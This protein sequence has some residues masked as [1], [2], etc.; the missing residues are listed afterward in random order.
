MTEVLKFGPYQVVKSLGK[1]GMGEVFLVKD[2]LCD[3]EVALKR[4]RPNLIGFKTM[5]ERFIREAKAAAQLTH[6]SIL[7]VYSIHQEEDL[8]YYTMPYVEGETLKT[9]LKSTRSSERKSTAQHPIGSSIPALMR[10]FWN[11]CQAMA[12]SHAQG[13]LHRDLKPE[14]V[15]I[16]KY[17]ETFIL[18]WGLAKPISAP[19]EE[20]ADDL[21]KITPGL[22]SPG[23]IVGT[24]TYMAPERAKGAPSSSQTDIYSLGVLL[25]LM[26]TLK[27]PFIRESIHTF[28]KTMHLEKLE[29]PIDAAPYRDI[30]RPIQEIAKKCL[31]FNTKE[32][33]ATVA[34]LLIDLEKYIEG[35]PEWIPVSTLSLDRKEDWEFQENVAMAKYVAITRGAQLIE[36]VNMMVAKRGFSGNLRLDADIHLGPGCRGIGFL[37]CLPSPKIHSGKEEGYCLWIGSA[38]E[39]SV[40]LTKGDIELVRQ[41]NSPLKHAN[42]HRLRIERVDRYIRCYVDGLL[43]LN[44]LSH[45]PLYGNFMGLLARDADFSMREIIVS[46][47]SHN[48]T[49]NCLAVPDALLAHKNYEEALNEYRR[50]GDSF[51]GRVESREALFRAGVTLLEQGIHQKRKSAKERLLHLANEEFFKLRHTPGAPLEYLGKSLIYKATGDIEEEIKCLELGLRKYREHPLTPQL[52]DHVIFRMH[53]SAYKNRRAAYH[54]TLLA[55]QLLP[56]VFETLENAVLKHNL[57]DHLEKLSFVKFSEKKDPKIINMLQRS[58]LAF[59]LNKTDSLLEIAERP[60]LE[61]DGLI[62]DILFYLLELGKFNE[63]TLLLSSNQDSTGTSSIT[64]CIDALRLPLKKFL[65]LHSEHLE[66]LPQRAFHFICQHYLDQGNAKE[67]LPY[68][69]ERE[70]VEKDFA[71]QDSAMMLAIQSL[72]LLKKPKEAWKRLQKLPKETRSS[73]NHPAFYLKACALQALK[74]KKATLEHFSILSQ[75]RYPPLFSLLGHYVRGRL[76]WKKTW[77]KSAFAYEKTALA[78]QLRVWRCS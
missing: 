40:I 43:V 60:E 31:A 45:T 54:F 78:R 10:I 41:L 19:E 11:I 58:A 46:I 38:K 22:T 55:L 69:L 18:D 32:R 16:G 27:L 25:Y 8:I 75:G 2:P 59:W 30:P 64:F 76:T 66:D 14:N 24:L 12:Y 71:L 51:P 28:R 6:P 57:F 63:A 77:N 1:G 39:P 74:G 73:E 3:R 68:I 7:P 49:V 36:W 53:E 15:M 34:E 23:K 48:V 50:I 52:I 5:R 13:Y 29:D 72:L 20:Y 65:K 9:I 37:L 26:L 70:K 67:V 61:W 42:W 33:Y 56:E 35:N 62:E 17:G 44:Y 47:S 4:I 21:P